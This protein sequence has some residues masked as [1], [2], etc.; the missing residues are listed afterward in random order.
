MTR[1]AS[2]CARSRA[3]GSG[4]ELKRPVDI[5][6]D[7]QLNIY[8][9]DSQAGVFII[10]RGGQLLATLGAGQLKEPVALTLGPD[11]SVLVYDKKARQIFRFH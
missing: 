5:A 9:A 7:A 3:R 1:R 2:R 4:F 8:V 10:G 6:V 11:G